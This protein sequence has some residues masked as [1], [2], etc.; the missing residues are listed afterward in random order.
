MCGI[1]IILGN[2]DTI[3]SERNDV[4]YEEIA[5]IQQTTTVFCKPQSLCFVESISND[6]YV[7][8]ELDDQVEAKNE[9]YESPISINSSSTISSGYYVNEG[10]DRPMED[11]RDNT[12][13]IE[14]QIGANDFTQQDDS[15]LYLVP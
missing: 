4:I 10:L 2:A 6:F 11:A 14:K 15:Y 12:E 9:P 8:E 5:E 13:Q 3:N 7:D 1:H